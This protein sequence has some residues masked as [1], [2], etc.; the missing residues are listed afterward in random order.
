MYN[1]LF[2]LEIR[3][4]NYVRPG[5]N[6]YRRIN[7][8]E[9]FKI[10]LSIEL[11]PSHKKSQHRG[12]STKWNIKKILYCEKAAAV[13]FANARNVLAVMAVYRDFKYDASPLNFERRLHA[14][15]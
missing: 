1:A 14:T 13:T 15:I 9:L 11:I 10:L 5:Q 4:K 6:F 3:I 12:V 7:D 8:P 2:K